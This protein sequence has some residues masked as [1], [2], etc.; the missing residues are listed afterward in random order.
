MS[1]VEKILFHQSCEFRY[2]K[3]VHTSS[4]KWHI[5]EVVLRLIDSTL[6]LSVKCLSSTDPIYND[7]NLSQVNTCISVR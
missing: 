5:S 3:L 4:I 7:Y 6:V 1:V 2:D